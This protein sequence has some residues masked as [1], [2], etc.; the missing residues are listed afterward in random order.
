MSPRMSTRGGEDASIAIV[1][2]PQHSWAF[3]ASAGICTAERPRCFC[4]QFDD[5]FVFHLAK[6]AIKLT[7]RI[8]VWRRLDTH[9]FICIRPHAFEAVRRCDGNGAHE[10]VAAAILRKLDGQSTRSIMT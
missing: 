9:E 7:Y 1:G 2:T 8:K 6:F 3:A 10:G 5:R 4:Q